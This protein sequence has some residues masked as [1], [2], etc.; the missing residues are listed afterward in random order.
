MKPSTT[1]ALGLSCLCKQVVAGGSVFAH[2]MVG[3]ITQDHANTDIQQAI[4][5]GFD[6]FAL[7]LMSTDGW[8]T[9]AV[10]AL[11][12]ASAG[13]EFK[14]FFSFDMTH[15]SDPSE[16]IP[17]LK[18]YV[19]NDNYYTYSGKPFVST[20]DGGT[21]TFGSS[22]PNS[23]WTNSFK[24][25]LSD[26]GIDVFFVP[27]FDDSS[28][29]PNDFFSTFSV[30]DG[31]FSW[32]TAWPGVNSG[33]VNVSDSV[34]AT[35]LGDAHSASKVY[36]MPLS[37][38]QFKHLDSSQNWYR[39]GESNIVDRMAQVLSLQPELVEVITWNDGGEGHYIGN[40]WEEAIS[41]STI[42]N[43]TN[44]LSHDG[45]QTLIPPFVSAYKSGATDIS[46]ISTSDGKPA[47]VM[48]YRELLVGASCSGDSLGKPS[49]MDD[50]EDAIN[51]AVILPSSGSYTINVYSNNNKIGSVTGTAGLNGG[52]ITGLA[53]GSADSQRVEVVDAS[54]SVVISATGTKDVSAEASGL[55][56]FN[57]VVVGMS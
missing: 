13:T 47:G 9:D 1:L 42:G 20:F 36:M 41:T 46:Q 45:W 11:F 34:D 6:A 40:V 39:R 49:G 25:V 29:Y 3:G 15:F 31:A 48:W 43:F 16:F 24:S 7:N 52:T 23:G 37:T 38:F 21:L 53:A 44:G 56:N 26:A 35:V 51:F 14:L 55:C 28:N 8:S 57:Y 32:E 33:K 5:A 54:G 22:D 4:A 30:V 18:D 27:D 10:S 2:Y 17:V 12:K 50:G 19:G